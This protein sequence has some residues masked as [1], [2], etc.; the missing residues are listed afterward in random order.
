MTYKL[1]I[2]IPQPTTPIAKMIK[3]RAPTDNRP[4]GAPAHSGLPRSGLIGIMAIS[5]DKLVHQKGDPPRSQLRFGT[6]RLNRGDKSLPIKIT[7]T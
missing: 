2:I 6:G 4:R 1:S 7:L 5:L 3:S